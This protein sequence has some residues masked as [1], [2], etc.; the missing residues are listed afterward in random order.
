MTS[1]DPQTGCSIADAPTRTRSRTWNPPDHLQGRSDLYGR[2]LK[3]ACIR[4][5]EGRPHLPSLPSSRPTCA[6]VRSILG[7]SIA[8]LSRACACARACSPLH[9]ASSVCIIDIVWPQLS[10]GV[11]GL[12]VVD[13]VYSALLRLT[14]TGL[15]SA[16]TWANHT[17]ALMLNGSLRN[18]TWSTLDLLAE[19]E[20]SAAGK[21]LPMLP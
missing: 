16:P 8:Q 12:S 9:A 6:H 1:R 2:P 3:H 20:P 17:G 18:E 7:L 21:P 13:G 4:P 5:L 19:P 14:P 15:L 11:C 10:A